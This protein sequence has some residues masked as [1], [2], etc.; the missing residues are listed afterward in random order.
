[1]SMA[2]H[3]LSH[4]HNLNR[5]SNTRTTHVI[6]FSVDICS[7]SLKQCEVKA[8]PIPSFPSLDL[9][10]ISETIRVI[11]RYLDSSSLVGNITR[12][13]SNLLAA[14]DLTLPEPGQD[15]SLSFNSDIVIDAA[16]EVSPYKHLL[17]R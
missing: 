17:P 7:N 14:A 10:A 1:M 15:E 12:L 2:N 11:R 4:I 6:H 9:D 5:R 16:N 13:S 8:P 3:H